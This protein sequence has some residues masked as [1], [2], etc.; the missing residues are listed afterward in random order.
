MAMERYRR[1]MEAIERERI[2]FLNKIDL[3][4]PSFEEQHQLEVKRVPAAAGSRQQY[5]LGT[6]ADKTVVAR[7]ASA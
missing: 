5:T 2:N 1:Q 6:H 4:Q 7:L 3:I